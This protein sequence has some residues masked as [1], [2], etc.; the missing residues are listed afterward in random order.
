MIEWINII[1]MILSSII[2]LYLYVKSVGP[3]ALEKK[4]GKGA[5]KK[6]GEYRIAASIAEMII[7]INYIIYFFYPIEIFDIPITFPWEWGISIT[8]AIIIALPSSVIMIK[9]ILDAGKEA[10]IPQIDQKLYQGIYKKIRHPQ[11]VGELPLWWSGSLVLNS[12]F[13]ALYST[14][15]I[16]IFLIM[17]RAEEKDLIIRFG[18]AYT[19][20]KKETGMIFPKIRRRRI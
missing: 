1:V 13:L 2:M 20:Y 9:G 4:V 10:M 5:Y 6:C 12:P 11:A 8:I 14:I 7:I 17:M 15:F 19:T 18:D 16:P 3:A